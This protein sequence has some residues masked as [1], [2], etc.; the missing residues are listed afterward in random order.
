[1]ARAS[2]THSSSDFTLSDSDGRDVHD[3]LQIPFRV[4]GQLFV[5]IGMRRIGRGRHEQQSVVVIG[6]DEGVDC[7]KA[8]AAGAVLDDN[9][10]A[11]ARR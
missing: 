8:V 1:L 4:I 5:R 7:D 6:A 11:P 2:A 3:G 9:R 10:L